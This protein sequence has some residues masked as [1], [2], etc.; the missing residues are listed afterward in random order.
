MKKGNA[1]LGVICEAGIPRLL[2]VAA[3]GDVPP[4]EMGDKAVFV[5]FTACS[6]AGMWCVMQD[7]DTG[8]YVTVGE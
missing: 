2:C 6:G 4:A 5:P 3:E 8:E 1:L 7:A